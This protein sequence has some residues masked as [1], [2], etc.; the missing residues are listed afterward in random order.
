LTRKHHVVFNLVAVVQSCTWLG[1]KIEYDVM[2]AGQ[3]LNVV[4]FDP[5]ELET[6]PPGTAVSVTIPPTAIRLVAD[7]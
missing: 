7:G 1:D 5:A 6:I 4:C 2:F 3:T